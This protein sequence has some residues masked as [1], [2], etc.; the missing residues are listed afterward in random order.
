MIV[1]YTKVSKTGQ[2]IPLEMRK[3]LG[4][5]SGEFVKIIQRDKGKI[6]IINF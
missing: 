1:K 5:K 6:K 2:I 4:I 3:S